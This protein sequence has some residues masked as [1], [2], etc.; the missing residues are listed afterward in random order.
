M[1]T[2]FQEYK[3]QQTLRLSTSTFGRFGTTVGVVMELK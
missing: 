1:T 3:T 2:D